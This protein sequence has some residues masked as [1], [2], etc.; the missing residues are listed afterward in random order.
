M[1]I[2]SVT[3]FSGKNTLVMCMK[4]NKS[5]CVG[6]FVCGWHCLWLNFCVSLVLCRPSDIFIQH[7]HL[8]IFECQCVWWFLKCGPVYIYKKANSSNNVANISHDKNQTC[9]VHTASK[10]KKERSS[11]HIPLCLYCFLCLSFFSE[12]LFWESKKDNALAAT[13]NMLACTNQI[14]I[15]FLNMPFQS[16]SPH[17]TT[18]PASCRCR[19]WRGPSS[20]PWSP[21][22]PLATVS[23]ASQRNVRRQLSYSSSSWSSPCWWRSSSPAPSWPR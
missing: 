14:G 16:S 13:V 18:R 21:R 10:K 4:W 3:A 17:P 5:K 20:S 9:H 23:A 1:I 19:P 8:L 12:L 6:D 15:F 2:F 11:W 7:C 22:Q